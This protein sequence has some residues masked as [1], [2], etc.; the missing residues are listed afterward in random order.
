MGRQSSLPQLLQDTEQAV[1]VF[2]FDFVD[3]VTC[4]EGAEGQE[5][6]CQGVDRAVE[7]LW[8]VI[9]DTGLEAGKTVVEQQG[10]HGG[11]QRRGA[12]DERSNDEGSHAQGDD[13]FEGPVEGAVHLAWRRRDVCVID[14][15]DDV[16][17][18]LGDG[19]EEA[20]VCDFR[21]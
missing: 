15:A 20:S 3:T 19:L 17:W 8:D 9:D 13:S 10:G 2:I 21:L 16:S 6:H 18:R 5:T 7:S 1:F 4:D 11:V 12:G 14:G